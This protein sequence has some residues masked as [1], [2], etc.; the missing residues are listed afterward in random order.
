[1]NK[2]TENFIIN[3]DL[4]G[5]RLDKAIS[6]HLSNISR[7]RV[8]ALI[9]QGQVS[10]NGVFGKWGSSKVRQGMHICI[11]IPDTTPP[12]ATAENIA[13]DIIFEDEHLLL[14]NKPSGMV[15]HPAPGNESGTLVN[16]ILHHAKDSLSGIGGIKRPG[17]VHRIDKDTSGIVVVAKSDIAHNGLTNLFKTHNIKRSYVAFV[18]GHTTPIQGTISQ[19]IGR[20]KTDRKKM[21]VL[22][23]DDI[24]G[25][26]AITHYKTLCRYSHIASKIECT[27]KTGRTHQIRVHMTHMG[28]GLIG[29]P[30]YG[31][32]P[33]GIHR[34][35]P[36]LYNFLQSFNRQALHAKSLGFTHPVT[37]KRIFLETEYP[38]DMQTLEKYLMID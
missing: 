37:E 4:D 18:W 13:L 9:K 10:I 35:T 2:I 19:N 21:S 30:V 1:M 26:T 3:T 29:D 22:P 38:K 25:K 20:H 15:V 27:L 6:T 8:Q 7:S 14:I 16:A 32:I 11:T 17:I 24:T 5:L 31:R 28:N 36:E 12:P 33:K 23:A 34:N